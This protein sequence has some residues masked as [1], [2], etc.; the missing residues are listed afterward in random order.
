[1][2]RLGE[3]R[4]LGTCERPFADEALERVPALRWNRVVV[5]WLLSRQHTGAAHG[6]EQDET[7]H[8]FPDHGGKGNC[9]RSIHRA[10]TLRPARYSDGLLPEPFDRNTKPRARVVAATLGSAPR[11]MSARTLR[12][13]SASSW[14]LTPDRAS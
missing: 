1:M 5:C 3:V 6:G 12:W 11:S 7:M 10:A 2:R 13:K 9:T 14:S 4:S 8:E